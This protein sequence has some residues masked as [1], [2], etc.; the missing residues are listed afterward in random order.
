MNQAL[1][2]SHLWVISKKIESMVSNWYLQ[3]HVHSNVIYN[4]Q[5]LGATQ[6]STNGQMDKQN[7][8]YRCPE[9]LHSFKGGH[10]ARCYKMREAWGRY[11]KWN[12][13]AIRRQILWFHLYK[14][15]KVVNS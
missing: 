4:S 11:A 15:S 3:T 14:A 2:I 12:K 8:V 1:V 9:V 10:V 5:K 7:M 13:S 6:M